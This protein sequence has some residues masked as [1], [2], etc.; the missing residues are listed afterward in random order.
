[1][2]SVINTLTLYNDRQEYFT[3]IPAEWRVYDLSFNSGFIKSGKGIS[4]S[5]VGGCMPG[6]Y[7]R[8]AGYKRAVL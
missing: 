7:G 2:V 6:G 8:T 3:K 1:M 4:D 5:F